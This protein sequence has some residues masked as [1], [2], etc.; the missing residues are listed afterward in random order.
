MEEDDEIDFKMTDE[1]FLKAVWLIDKD[2]SS[3]EE[4]W[5]PKTDLLGLGPQKYM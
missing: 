4:P 3:D 2:V 5:D 1:E